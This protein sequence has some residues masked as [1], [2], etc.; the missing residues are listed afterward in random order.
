MSE[1]M[2]QF[3][4]VFLAGVLLIGFIYFILVRAISTKNYIRKSFYMFI[5]GLV[6]FLFLIGGM[7]F[8]FSNGLKI[9]NV[10]M[11]YFAFPIVSFLFIL[12]FKLFKNINAISSKAMVQLWPTGIIRQTHI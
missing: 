2:I 8:D 9:E 6:I 7:I 12:L 5:S 10:Q 1:E 11:S 3:L 4:K